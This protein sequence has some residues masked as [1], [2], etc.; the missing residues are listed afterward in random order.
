MAPAQNRV[1]G[2]SGDCLRH[3]LDPTVELRARP[4]GTTMRLIQN[5]PNRVA[6]KK[7]KKGNSG[8]PA[9][10][11]RPK[12]RFRCIGLPTSNPRCCEAFTKGPVGAGRP[13]RQRT[14]EEMS[15]R[16]IARNRKRSSALGNSENSHGSQAGISKTGVR[17]MYA[18]GGPVFGRERVP[19]SFANGNE[20]TKTAGATCGYC[21][22]APTQRFTRCDCS[23]AGSG[24]CGSFKS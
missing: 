14:K 6:K 4:K 13:L 18:R 12:T 3:N 2:P 20:A 17:A 15:E 16:E 10:R 9:C 8:S 11:H 7:K 5:S 23:R 22:L 24:C 19:T 1:K 21:H